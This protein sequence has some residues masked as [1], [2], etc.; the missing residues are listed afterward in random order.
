MQKKVAFRVKFLYLFSTEN[1]VPRIEKDKGVSLVKKALSTL[2]LAAFAL[3]IAPVARSQAGPVE[4][5]HEVQI[6][7]GGG[8]GVNGSQSG[9][10]IWNLGL[11]YGLV[12]TRSHGPG[13][14]RGRVEYAVEAVPAFLV[15]QKTNTAYGLGVN[16][17]AFKWLMAPRS[18]VMPYFEVGGGTLFTNTKVPE[19]TSRINFT[20]TGALGLHFLRS[21]YNISTEVRFMHISNAGLATPNPGIN[22][23]QFRLGF[24]RFSQKE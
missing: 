21:K 5:G 15:V 4:G 6:W 17:F 24:G 1:P 8:H 2:L 11:R 13:F 9:D 22:T 23:I 19:G 3:A 7:T 20:T 10:G 12:L 14:L 18:S 16:P